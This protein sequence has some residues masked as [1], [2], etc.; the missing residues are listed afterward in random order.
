MLQIELTE[1]WENMLE[2]RVRNIEQKTILLRLF[3]NENFLNAGMN[4][5]FLRFFL[6]LK[7]L[8]KISMKD[9]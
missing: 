3:M 5:N 8:S 4:E 1:N 9:V 7:M 2:I 6:S